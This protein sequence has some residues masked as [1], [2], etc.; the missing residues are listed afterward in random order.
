VSGAEQARHGKA[1]PGQHEEKNEGRIG[2]SLSFP[3]V[4]DWW[5]GGSREWGLRR[6]L[7]CMRGMK[8]IDQLRHWREADVLQVN[9]VSVVKTRGFTHRYLHLR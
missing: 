3:A 4:K 8:W 5:T 1:D 7:T 9:G 2:G 6:A